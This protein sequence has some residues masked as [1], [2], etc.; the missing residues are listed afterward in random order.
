M[1]ES[2][3]GGAAS[4]KSIA[5][6]FQDAANL[7]TLAGLL[8]SL[9]AI[10]LAVR[11]EFEAAAIALVFA[12]LFDVVDGPVARMLKSRTVVDREFGANLD[13]LADVISAGVA[14]SVVLLAFGEFRAI[15]L[16]GAFA[17]GVAAAMRLSYF[18]VHGLDEGSGRYVGLPTDMAVIAFAAL[19]L[20]D[21]PLSR[22]SSRIVM[23]GGALVLA[24]LM[25]SAL[26]IPKLSGRWFL[27]QI[28]VAA[29]LAVVH[30]LRYAS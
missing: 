29:V 26:P 14:L 6:H 13:S 5:G 22:E 16:P 20:L 8:S 19:M 3:V 11:G 17:L 30:A 9:L 25:A 15:Y 4:R 23:Y 12:F 7:L 28:A 1:S 2:L 18:N 21:E 27:S 24:G 10:V